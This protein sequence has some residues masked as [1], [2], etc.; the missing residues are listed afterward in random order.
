VLTMSF[1]FEFISCVTYCKFCMR[2]AISFCIAQHS[3]EDQREDREGSIFGFELGDSEQW[4][5]VL[6]WVTS[7]DETARRDCCFGKVTCPI[8]M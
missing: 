6:G 8:P 4:V 3:F 7:E 5:L 1:V 2:P